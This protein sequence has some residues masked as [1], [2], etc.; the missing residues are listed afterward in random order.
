MLRQ[1]RLSRPE[2]PDVQRL[3][4]SRFS[5]M[6]GILQPAVSALM[7]SLQLEMSRLEL[8]KTSLNRC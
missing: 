3:L 1:E 2:Q 5:E 6:T 4:N 7:R 8:R